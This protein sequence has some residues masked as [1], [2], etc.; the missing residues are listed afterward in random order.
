[1]LNKLQTIDGPYVRLQ[2][3]K[4][5]DENKKKTLINLFSVLGK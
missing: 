4:S 5:L 2:I 3:E 1:M